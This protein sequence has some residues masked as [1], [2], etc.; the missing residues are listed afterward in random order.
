[1]SSEGATDDNQ[2][3]WPP[4][5]S[6]KSEAAQVQERPSR[7]WKSLGLGVIVGAT[8][9]VTTSVIE[10]FMITIADNHPD[11]AAGYV[12]LY[13]TGPLLY[14]MVISILYSKPNKILAHTATVVSFLIGI[15][16]WCCLLSHTDM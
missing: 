9:F 13:A 16:L 10:I 7:L 14:I 2:Q 1:M 8:I 6:G 5:P 12:W 15:V 11:P 3:I 4:A